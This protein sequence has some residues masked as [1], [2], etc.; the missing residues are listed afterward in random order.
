MFV[1]LYTSTCWL[2]ATEAAIEAGYSAKSARQIASE[3][4][5]KLHIRTAIDERLKALH[6]GADE[7]LARHAEHASAS[8]EDFIDID[9]KGLPVLNLNKARARGKLHL[10]K[11]LTFDRLGH[12][13]IE[14]HDAQAANRDLGRYHKLFVERHE[15]TGKNG[16]PI[17][18]DLDEWKRKGQQQLDQVAALEDDDAD[19]D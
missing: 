18:H 13:T 7:V 6:L 2:N 3:N 11:K 8:I 5:S 12:P 19:E 15:V 14:L 10:I 16:G 4:L 17:E 9:A 1:L